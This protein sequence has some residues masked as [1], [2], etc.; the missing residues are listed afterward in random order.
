MTFIQNNRNHYTVSQL[1]SAL[2]FPRS[3]YYKALVR[4][5]SNRQKEYEEFSQKVKK[6]YEDSKQRYGAV[7][8]CRTLND[9]GTPCSIKRVQRHM[10]K[11]GLRSVVVKKYNHHANHGRVPD[12][13]E[14]ILKRD[15]KA[16]TI[17]QK[18]CTDITY[19][20]VQKEGWTCLASVMD[21]YSRK[22]I[23]YAMARP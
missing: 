6:S 15:F 3:T 11:Q 7:K 21:L 2:K 20:H 16:E 18:W 22:I 14:N 19:I 23:G 8:I 4:V 13:K 12:D 10:A 9:S 17:N 5:P 1:C